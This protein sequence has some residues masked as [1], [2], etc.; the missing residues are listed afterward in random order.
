M[1]K[2]LSKLILKL[3]IQYFSQCKRNPLNLENLIEL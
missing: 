1:K 3:Q 2:Y